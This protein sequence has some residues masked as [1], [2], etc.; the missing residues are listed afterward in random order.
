M[1][2]WNNDVQL[3][4]LGFKIGDDAFHVLSGVKE[5][6][7]KKVE[8]CGVFGVADTRIKK[9]FLKLRQAYSVERVMG[10]LTA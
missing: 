7:S 4:E 9:H 2:F 6:K 5:R 1:L 3:C 8:M 10:H